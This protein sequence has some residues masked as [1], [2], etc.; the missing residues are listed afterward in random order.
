MLSYCWGVNTDERENSLEGS[1]APAGKGGDENKSFPIWE[2]WGI[3]P[4]GE[5]YT[6]DSRPKS[7]EL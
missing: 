5:K 6:I 3:L 7:V 4:G 2:V 1:P